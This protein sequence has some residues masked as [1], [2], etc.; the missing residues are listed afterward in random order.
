MTGTEDLAALILSRLSGEGRKIVALAGPPGAGKSA[1]ARDLA[2]RLPDSAVLEADGFHYDNALLDRLGRRGRKGAP[3]TFDCAGLAAILRRLRDG[4]PDLVVP[5]FD[6]PLD[7]AR[8]GARMIP[9]AA[10]IVLV[11]GNYLALQREPWAGLRPFFDLVVLL[12][13]P[14]AELE[15]R[16]IARWTDLGRT[17]EEARAWAEGNDLPNADLVAT[18]SGGEDLRWPS[19]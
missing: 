3:D 5:I 6:R 2:S 17:P 13:V 7:L 1:T 12:E 10:R 8:A 4:E 11:E 9:A 16:L 19:F 14:R 18:A 15:R